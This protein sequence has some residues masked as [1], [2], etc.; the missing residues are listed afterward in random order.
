MFT[1]QRKQI[2]E[3]FGESLL[4]ETVNRL[5]LYLEPAHILHDIARNVR[6]RL[7]P[8]LIQAG[9]CKLQFPVLSLEFRVRGE[10]AINLAVFLLR[11]F[12]VDEPDQ[13][14][15]GKRFRHRHIGF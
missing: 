3:G 9:A 2:P 13:I 1:A 7:H 15:L 14:V 8:G 10:N 5:L 6:R 4:G 12:S 11:G